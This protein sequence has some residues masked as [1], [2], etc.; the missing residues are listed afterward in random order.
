LTTWSW[1]TCRR[2]CREGAERTSP[3]E[4]DPASRIDLQ[5]LVEADTLGDPQSPLLFDAMA[6]W[7]TSAFPRGCCTNSGLTGA[8]LIVLC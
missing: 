7:L 3:V 4:K 1:R 5:R 8:F 6:L 2:E